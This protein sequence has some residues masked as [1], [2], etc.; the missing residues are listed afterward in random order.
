MVKCN[1]FKRSPGKVRDAQ[2]G[3]RVRHLSDLAE[4]LAYLQR[5]RG[6]SAPAIAHLETDSPDISRW[7]LA[8]DRDEFALC[9][10]SRSTSPTYLFVLGDPPLL[11]HL[12]A[13]VRLPGDVFLTCQPSHLAV[14]E[15]YYHLDWQCSMRRM[16]VDRDGFVPATDGAIRLRPAHLKEINRLYR[17]HGNN[18]FSANQ[19]RKGVY[20]GAWSDE[21]LVAV[22]GTHVISQRYGIAYVGNVLTQ[23]AYR[24]RGFATMC[25]SAVTADLLD[26]CTQVVLNVEPHNL[27]AIKAYASLGYKDD[28][29]IIEA[30]GKRQGLIGVI[31]TNLFG[32]PK[33]AEKYVEGAG[34]N[35]RL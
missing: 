33:A 26:Y 3:V 30:F 34:A 27:P 22:A 24:N 31:I 20:Y 4:A 15:G 32:K 23:P 11:D 18:A 2:S 25:T 7:Y 8:R 14:I 29:A 6:Y 9:L 13:S 17:T 19:I 12:L 28:C 21:Q 5:E 1:L 35:G 16:V 10:I